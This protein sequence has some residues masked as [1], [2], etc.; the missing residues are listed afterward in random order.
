MYFGYIWF[1]K[2]GFLQIRTYFNDEIKPTEECETNLIDI[3]IDMYKKR[4]MRNL[5]QHCSPLFDLIRNT[6]LI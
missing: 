5:F 2:T 3:F 1:I 4:T 6:Q